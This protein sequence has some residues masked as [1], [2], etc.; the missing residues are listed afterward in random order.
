MGKFTRAMPMMPCCLVSIAVFLTSQPGQFHP[1]HL[2]HISREREE[3]PRA[4]IMRH[5]HCHRDKSELSLQIP[6]CRVPV[7]HRTVTFAVSP[8]FL[9]LIGRLVYL[10]C[11]PFSLLGTFIFKRKASCGH[12]CLWAHLLFPFSLVIM[13]MQC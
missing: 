2:P 7:Q 11:R 6:Q 9:A 5:K 8:P 10:F 3:S 13:T 4:S 12:F 1:R